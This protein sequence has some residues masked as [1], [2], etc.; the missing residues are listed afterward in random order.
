[1]KK[2]FTL[3]LL[4]S[5]LSLSAQSVRFGVQAAV[6][7]PT[8]DLTNNAYF[9]LQMGG[10][11]KADLSEGHGIM[12]RADVAFYSQNNDYN[13]SN[14]ALAADY[15]YHFERNQIGPYVLAGVSQQVYHTS[16]HG[17]DTNDSGLGIDLGAGFD[18]D[19]NVGLQVRYTTNSFNSY[20]YA[21]VNLGVT[22]TF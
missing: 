7:L 10:H 16:L 1:M 15:T 14:Y 3:I 17:L 4:G 19:R 21:A 12:A 9:G 2:T 5:A 18:V 11:A 22:Y 13:V 20:N 6:S 8:N